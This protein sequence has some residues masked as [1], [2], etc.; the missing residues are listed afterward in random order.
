MVKV[1]ILPYVRACG[2]DGGAVARR[3]AWGTESGYKGGRVLADVWRV[4]WPAAR[5]PRSSRILG[6]AYDWAAIIIVLALDILVNAA[7]VMQLGRSPRGVSW[8]PPPPCQPHQG[9]S[10]VIYPLIVAS[11]AS[12]K[13]L[14]EL[15]PQDLAKLDLSHLT[16]CD[17]GTPR[18][19]PP[20][21]VFLLT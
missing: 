16:G 1:Y 19:V 20:S 13:Q 15:L 3:C 14:Q 5:V 9:P 12:P 18:G 8:L 10:A 11:I 21:L 7:V 17:P 6:R 4:H 2:G